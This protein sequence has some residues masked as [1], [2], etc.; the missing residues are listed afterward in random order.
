MSPADRPTAFI[1][2]AQNTNASI[3]PMKI[4]TRTLGFIKVTL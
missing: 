3:T 2:I 1:V 4:P